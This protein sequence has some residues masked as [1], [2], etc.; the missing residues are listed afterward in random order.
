M[1]NSL[2]IVVVLVAALVGILAFMS[3][4]KNRAAINEEPLSDTALL[5]GLAQ[6]LEVKPE[7]KEYGYADW[8][9]GEQTMPLKGY[10]FFVGTVGVNG[11]GKYKELQSDD[12]LQISLQNLTPLIKTSDSYFVSLDFRKNPANTRTIGGTPA[13]HYYGY[14]KGSTKCLIRLDEQTDPFGNFFCGMVDDEQ[15]ALQQEF[16]SLFD[17]DSEKVVSFRVQK[18][19]EDVALGSANYTYTGFMW[20]AKKTDDTW[21]I[22]WRGNDVAPC[23]E[24]EEF[25]IPQSIYGSCYDEQT[26]EQ[27]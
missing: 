9:D 13:A 18:V 10:S 5:N 6:D 21:T 24:M 27:R 17:N 12:L 1:R 23:L 3:S 7:I 25:G 20:I 8:I 19:Q 2:M 22:V 4:Q 14:D 16:R 15:L 26:G 11:I